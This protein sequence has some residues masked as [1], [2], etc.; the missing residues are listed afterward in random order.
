MHLCRRDQG[1]WNGEIISDDLGEPW[2]QSQVPLGKG[3]PRTLNSMKPCDQGG[4]EWTHVTT[5]LEMPQLP[6]ATGGREQ[7]LCRSLQGR[8]P[9]DLLS[10]VLVSDFRLPWGL[11]DI[12]M[13]QEAFPFTAMPLMACHPYLYNPKWLPELQLLHLHFRQLDRR[14]MYIFSL[15][16]HLSSPTDASH[17]FSLYRVITWSYLSASWARKCT[18]KMVCRFT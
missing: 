17:C 6:D 3:G 9:A 2:M 7:T 11:C 18:F 10:L 14:N 16:K 15:R 13:H 4:R 8:S 1:S 12:I 5:N